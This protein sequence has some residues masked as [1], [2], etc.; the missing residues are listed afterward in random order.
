MTS[1]AEYLGDLR[2]KNTHLQ[3]GS[4]YLTDAP[5]DNHGKGEAFSPTDTVATALGNCILTTMG[6]KAEDKDIDLKGTIAEITK[7]MAL[8]PRRIAKIKV[9]IYFPKNY[10]DKIKSILKYTAFHCPVFQ[11]LH[12]EMEKEINFFYD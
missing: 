10:P 9:E 7:T 8:N 4:N 11:S 12:P 2:V 3:S 1:K 5:I 6:I